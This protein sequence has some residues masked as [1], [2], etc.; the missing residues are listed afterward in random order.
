MLRTPAT[1][2]PNRFFFRHLRSFS[3]DLGGHPLRKCNLPGDVAPRVGMDL[4]D[5]G[6][7]LLGEA[8]RRTDDRWPQA[9][10]NE[11]DLAIDESAHEDILAAANS[12]REFEDLAAP[13]VRPP[14]SANGTLCDGCRK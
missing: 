12:L 14:A 10:V 1:E 7:L 5:L 11:C 13:R 3:L 4:V 9:T 8:L 6:E 2:F